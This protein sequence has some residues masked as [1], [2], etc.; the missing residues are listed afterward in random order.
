MHALVCLHFGLMNSL[1]AL[2]PSPYFPFQLDCIL[3][4]REI[5]VSCC[6]EAHRSSEGDAESRFTP[7]TRGVISLPP[8]PPL[9]SIP[10]PCSAPGSAVLGAGGT[11]GL[12]SRWQEG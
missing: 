3:G 4:P 9:V 11:A 6:L 2:F 1:L 8:V 12:G 7:L 5:N 10:Q